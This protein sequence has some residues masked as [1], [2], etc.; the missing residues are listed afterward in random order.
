M[1]EGLALMCGI[2]GIVSRTADREAGEL[3]LAATQALTHRGPDGE[4]FWRLAGDRAGLCSPR[5]LAGRADMVLG[6]RRLSIVDI[7]GGA[8][9]MGNEDG[10]VWV[11][12]N[13]EIY[14]HADLRQELEHLG[15]RYRTQCDTET[16]VHGWEEWRERLFGRL[17]GIFAFAIADLRRREIV[18]VRDPIGV[19]P[20]YVGTSAG[21]TW[22][23]SELAA[24]AETGLVS[25]GLSPDAIKLFL[26]FRFIPSPYTIAPNAW[27]LPPGHY[28]KLTSA[29]AGTEPRFVAFECRIRSSANPRSSRDWGEALIAEL[30]GAVHRQ[31]MADVP[32]ASLLSG[33]VDSSLITQ[34]MA[35]H[36]PYAPQ[37]FGIGMRSEGTANEALAAERAAAELGVPHS[38]T[39]LEDEAY[40]SA[41]PTVLG[42]IGEPIAN[43]SA[44]MIRTICEQVGRSHK[45][46]LCGQGADEPL[47]GYPRHM[48][49]RLQRFGRL[50][51]RLSRAVTRH[52]FGKESATRLDRALSARD[53]TE[54]YV[55]IFSVLPSQEIDQLVRGGSATA[56]ELARAAVERW[57]RTRDSGDD[58]NDLL[59]VDAR[60]SLADDLLII[61]DHTAMRS[62]VELRVPFLDLA[63]LELV[64]RMP[65]KYKVSRLGERKWLYRKAA[66]QHL[67]PDLAHRLCGPTKRFQRKRGFSSPLSDWFDAEHGLLASN[68]LWA[69][70]LR[71]RPELAAERIEEALGALGEEGLSRRRSVLYS[72]AQWLETNRRPMEAVA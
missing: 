53:R 11:S 41:W 24:A 23:A 62:S 60:L 44:L 21:R 34:M 16:L 28:V 13:G 64:E 71:A 47:G 67:P 57:V 43:S 55:E 9:P 12:F 4:G 40:V 3:V 14:N 25:T 18:L 27:K 52:A 32:V 72:L 54:R 2:A 35:A 22:F 31:L 70:A 48:T 7:D 65:S 5:D 37:T 26:T 51:P 8:Q 33:G 17:N 36:L 30:D 19:K 15:H 63:M 46:A 59:F 6:H 50:S 58:V 29:D 69:R 1:P 61:G 42:Q 20:L 10:S 49:E 38:S 45:V 39:V 68:E 56:S 66:A